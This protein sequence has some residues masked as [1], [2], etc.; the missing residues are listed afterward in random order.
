MVKILSDS[1]PQC[2]FN[3]LA[4]TNKSIHSVETVKISLQLIYCSDN[5]LNACNSSVMHGGIKRVEVF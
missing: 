2:N 1:A 4:A 3:L 5:Q